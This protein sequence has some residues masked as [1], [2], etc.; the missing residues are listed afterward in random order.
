[1]SNISER[2]TNNTYGIFKSGRATEDVVPYTLEEGDSVLSLGL[3]ISGGV[4][5]LDV[6]IKALAETY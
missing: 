5:V 6:F 1:M 4:K 2:N 3:E